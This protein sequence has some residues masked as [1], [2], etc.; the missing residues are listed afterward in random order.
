MKNWADKQS[1]GVFYKQHD[2]YPDIIISTLTENI[3]NIN[4]KNYNIYRK[5]EIQI[6]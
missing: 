5:K 6:R 1:L 2:K 4:K 3:A